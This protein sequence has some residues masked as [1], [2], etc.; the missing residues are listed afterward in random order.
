MRIV[1]SDG[2][3]LIDLRKASLLDAF[4][5]LPCEI[6]IPNTLF[7]DGLLKF[8]NAQKQALIRGGLKVIDLSGEM[9]LRA[10]QFMRRTPQLSI[11]DGFALALA[12]GHA[13]CVL[14]DGRGSLRSVAETRGIEVRGV[15]WVVDEIHA[16]R[17]GTAAMLHAAL[18]LLEKDAAARL[19]A[20]ELTAYIRR[21]DRLRS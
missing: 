21:Y 16:N 1:V 19:P 10:Q 9:V 3:C 8:T 11:H 14:L 15:L 4:L 12:E 13:G 17:I 20:R 6:I 5:N 7:E 2:S 18:L